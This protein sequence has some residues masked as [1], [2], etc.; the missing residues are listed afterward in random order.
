MFIGLPN[1]AQHGRDCPGWVAGCIVI[2]GFGPCSAEAQ[3]RKE[4]A[5]S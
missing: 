1:G 4:S 3:D 2:Y 5:Q